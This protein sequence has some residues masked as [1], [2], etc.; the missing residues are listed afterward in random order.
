MP[1]KHMDLFG[2][3]AP[4]VPGFVYYPDFITESEEQELLAAIQDIPLHSFMFHGYEAKRRVKSFGHNY[5]FDEKKLRQGKKIP[6]D[7]RFLMQR[8]GLSLAI[9]PTEIRELL[10]TE[11]PIGAQI[12][13]HRDAFP[14]EVVAGVSLLADCTFRLRPFE[15]RKQ[16]RKSIRSCV[17]KRRSLYVI[18]G[19]ARLEWQHSIPAVQQKRYSITMRTMRGSG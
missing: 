7:F 1:E 10:V 14:F 12:N 8:V 5:S 9:D 15:R 2:E 19:E 11:Y 17:V 13:W 4:L 18:R 16:S 3:V 6:E